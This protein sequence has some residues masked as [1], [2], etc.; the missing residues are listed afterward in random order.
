[1]VIRR[2]EQV[3]WQLPSPFQVEFTFK[4][5]LLKHYGSEETKSQFKPLGKSSLAIS[6]FFMSGFC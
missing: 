4:P 3:F 6:I 5:S 1:M 2:D